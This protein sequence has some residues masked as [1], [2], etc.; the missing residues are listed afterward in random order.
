VRLACPECSTEVI[1]VRAP[2]NDVVVTCGGSPM[3]DLSAPRPGSG[4]GEVATNGE[5]GSMIGKRY[6]D[7][8]IGIE[9]LCT[10]AGPG[11][12]ACDGRAMGLRG[13]KPLPSSD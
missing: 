4:H 10:K 7:D 12:L 3:V 1:V 11:P 5:G 8:E 9:L 13:A 6:V 2:S